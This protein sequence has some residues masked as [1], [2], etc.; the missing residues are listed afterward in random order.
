MESPEAA[1]LED[2][3]SQ[4]HDGVM[5]ESLAR[6]DGPVLL[7]IRA[8]RG[9]FDQ[10]PPL[11]PD[12]SL[13]GARARLAELD[14]AVVPDVNHYTVLLGQRGASEVARLNS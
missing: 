4:L 13:P 9:L 12:A 6:L 11:Y 8:P 1:V 2:S 3:A 10:V 5:E 14:D 7:L